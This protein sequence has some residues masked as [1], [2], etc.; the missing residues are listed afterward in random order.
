MRRQ[1]RRNG[2]SSRGRGRRPLKCWRDPQS[3]E[4]WFDEEG[5]PTFNIDTNRGGGAGRFKIF[6]YKT[7]TDQTS[8]EKPH[9]CSTWV[10]LGHDPT[11]YVGYGQ[12]YGFVPVLKNNF[13]WLQV[14]NLWQQKGRFCL[15]MTFYSIDPPYRTI[16]H[17]AGSRAT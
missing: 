6:I 8:P 1:K 17:G 2:G 11:S 15:G 10:G 13:H 12:E 14:S 3:F 7:E 9:C 5:I 16:P 4:T